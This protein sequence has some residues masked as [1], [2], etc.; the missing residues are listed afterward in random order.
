MDCITRIVLT[1]GLVLTLSGLVCAGPEE[2]E[3]MR[4]E[5]AVAGQFYPGDRETLTAVIDQMVADAQPPELQGSVVG[6]QVPHAGYPYSGPTAAHAFRLLQGLD[7]V[8]VVMFGT[9][10]RVFLDKAAVYGA[11]EWRTPLGSVPVDSAVAK[12][13][14][15][16]ADCLADMPE[17]HRL[18]HSI[19]VQVPFLQRVLGEFSIV[20][21]MVLQ[22]S[23]E[24]CEAVG[25]AVARA[26]AGRRAVL[27]ASSDLYHGESYEEAKETDAVTIGFL[28]DFD[29]PGLYR[30]LGEGDAQ[31]CG[32]AALV[33]LMLAARELGADTSVVLHATNSNDV[34]GERGGYCVGY[35][36][37]A[38]LR[39]RATGPG[40]GGAS[41]DDESLTDEERQGLLRIARTTI[42]SHVRGKG[43]PEPAAPSDRLKERRGVFVTLHEQGELRGCIG[44]IEAVKPL[45]LA[46]S[47]MAVAASTEDP[48][49][50]PV[51][52]GELAD[53]DIEITVLSPLRRITDPESV[54]VGHHGLVV[55]K[56]RS[57]GLLLPQVPV[58]QGWDRLEFLEGTCRKAWL[59]PDAWKDKDTELYVFTG[60]VFGEK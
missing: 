11:G 37:V 15:R 60:Q 31:A 39:S 55:R 42:E 22:P 45:Y 57:S 43:V 53:I 41:A 5:P 34:T 56:G 49:F 4:R 58:E 20:P 2:P 17:A 46:V 27:V 16:A 32:G 12:A 28:R 25:H 30:A 9:S 29:P 19:E 51:T 23:W 8:V 26:L 47:E 33:C 14:V 38:F 48:R 59:P 6:I 13:I 50:P 52:A 3:M 7:S 10:H 36:A 1:I 40:A 21:I 54:V 44:Y 24:Q 18:E 35:S